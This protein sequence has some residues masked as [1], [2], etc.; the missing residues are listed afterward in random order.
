VKCDYVRE[1]LLEKLKG[2]RVLLF[3][4]EFEM[5]SLADG[6]HRVIRGIED[7]LEY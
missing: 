2:I 6:A 7:A 4:G 5:E 1:R 3:P